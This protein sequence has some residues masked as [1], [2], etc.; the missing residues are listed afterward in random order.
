VAGFIQIFKRCNPK[1]DKPEP[2]NQIHTERGV[3]S[4]SSPNNSKPDRIETYK[5]KT[6]LQGSHVRKAPPVNLV[7]PVMRFCELGI[8]PPIP[9]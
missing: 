1:P 6:G 5:N 2:E 4:I 3:K 7:H 9:A 8:T